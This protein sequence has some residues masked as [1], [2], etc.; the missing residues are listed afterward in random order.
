MEQTILL[1]ILII[2]IVSL[3]LVVVTMIFTLTGQGKLK[4]TIKELADS[5]TSMQSQLETSKQ[6]GKA[7]E[8][9]LS[10]LKS[11]VSSAVANQ[12]E[13]GTKQLKK[14]LEEVPKMQAGQMQSTMTM[15]EIAKEKEGTVLCR[16]CYKPYS[17]TESKC[18]FCQARQS[19]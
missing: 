5:V 14:Q 12:M 16:S 2:S 10:E 6:Q 13:Y 9:F 18:P 17:V 8:A 4:R 19:R 7:D 15:T 11:A 1:G 3:C